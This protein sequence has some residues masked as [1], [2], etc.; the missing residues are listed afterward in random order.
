[1]LK[2]VLAVITFGI[3]GLV[4]APGQA[5]TKDILFV[6]DC[7]KSQAEINFFVLNSGE[8]KIFIVL[9]PDGGK[10]VFTEAYA[11][12][13]SKNRYPKL[14]ETSILDHGRAVISLPNLALT[15]G[16]PGK[17]LI[18][19]RVDPGQKVVINKNC[20]GFDIKEWEGP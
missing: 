13:W 6:N 11:R 17:V 1:M 7:K 10:K 8:D 14:P 15:I 3:I 19:N 16:D 9:D 20:K 4:P 2:V 18:I 5:N 12:V